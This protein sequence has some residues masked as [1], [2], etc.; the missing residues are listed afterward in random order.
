VRRLACDA[1]VETVVHGGDGK[2]IGIGRMSRIVPPKVMRQLRERDQA[3]TVCG[4][5]AGLQAHHRTHWAHGGRTDL[6]NLELVCRRC[7]RLIHDLGFRLVR[8]RLGNAKL[9]R[10]NGRPV[11]SRPSPL[12]PEVRERF[13][14]PARARPVPLRC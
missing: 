2:T 8:D 1:R 5:T 4:R 7:H 13:L 3:C 10:R 9:L 6:D 12:R 11:T 14:G